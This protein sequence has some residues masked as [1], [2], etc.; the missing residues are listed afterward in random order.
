V[1]EEQVRAALQGTRSAREGAASERAHQIAATLLSRPAEPALNPAPVSV[2]RLGRARRRA[3]VELARQYIRKHLTEPLQLADL[4]SNTH[5]QARS[6]EYGFQEV[7]RLSPMRY[8][9]SRLAR[10]R[11]L[12]NDVADC[13]ASPRLPRRWLHLSQ[14]AVDYRNVFA[15]TCRDT[16]ARADCQRNERAI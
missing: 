12:L 13:A 11:Q 6:L 10:C 2:A 1:L 5:L 7:V 8:V 16:A 15:E 14:F 4:C 9:K 3:A